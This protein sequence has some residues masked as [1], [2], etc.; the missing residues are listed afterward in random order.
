MKVDTNKKISFGLFIVLKTLNATDQLCGQNNYF[1]L[2][3]KEKMKNINTFFIFLFLTLSLV[4]KAKAR[5]LSNIDYQG[6]GT[7]L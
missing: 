3:E 7:Q 6:K 4:G 2:C 5:I 1:N